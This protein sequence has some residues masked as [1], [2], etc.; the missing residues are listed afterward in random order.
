ME[1]EVREGDHGAFLMAVSSVLCSSKSTCCT[2]SAGVV[3]DLD[4]NTSLVDE[5]A[6]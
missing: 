5:F 1:L 4:H 3:S 6:K 2:T